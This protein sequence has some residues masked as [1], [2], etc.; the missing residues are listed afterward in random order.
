MYSYRDKCIYPTINMK[1]IILQQNT[2]KF[3]SFYMNFTINTIKCIS[4]NYFKFR[5]LFWYIDLPNWIS[6]SEQCNELTYWNIY[7][8]T[9]TYWNVW[10]AIRTEA[11]SKLSNRD[12]SKNPSFAPLKI[13]PI[14]TNPL[15]Y[16][17]S[18]VMISKSNSFLSLDLW[19]CVTLVSL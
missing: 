1:Y 7:L 3:S 8:H 12:L 2:H 9:P 11:H 13:P 16:I 18:S 4:N 17:G 5:F 19:Q 14:R 15:I 10:P 6:L